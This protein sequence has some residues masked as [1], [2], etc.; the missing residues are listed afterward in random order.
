M[1][2]ILEFNEYNNLSKYCNV[3]TDD[4]LLEMCN[5]SPKTTGIENVY[6]WCGPNP[7]SHD[8]RIKISNVPDKWSKSDCF[9]ITIPD[10]RIIGEVNKSLIDNHELN[11]IKRFI[12][13]NIDIINQ[14]SEEKISTDEFISK[15][16]SLREV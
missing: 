4:E 14:Y 15:I 8:K 13:E 16:K 3:I 7:H 9:T 1:K 10:L 2:K 5:I 12:L 6:I 11:K